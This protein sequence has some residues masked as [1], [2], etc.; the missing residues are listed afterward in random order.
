ML[1]G[2]VRA[3]CAVQFALKTCRTVRLEREQLKRAVVSIQ[4]YA[5]LLQMPM[6][7]RTC[8]LKPLCSWAT[9][10]RTL[11]GCTERW[12]HVALHGK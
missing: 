10:S 3:A 6:Q 9:M 2:Q 4:R 12:W 11:A 5:Q 1:L 7:G 8:E